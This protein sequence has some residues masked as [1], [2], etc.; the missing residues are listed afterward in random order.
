MYNTIKN[1]IGKQ[2]G[3]RAESTD[4]CGAL[5]ASKPPTSITGVENTS[6]VEMLLDYLAFTYVGLM[7]TAVQIAELINGGIDWV[8]LDRGR[9][10]Y[11]KALQCNNVTIYYDGQEDMGIHVVLTGKGMR[12]IE[13]LEDFKGWKDWI[14]D[15]KIEGVT[16]T[17]I[18]VAI[19][20]YRGKVDIDH[21]RT[22][23][24][25]MNFTTHF[26]SYKP[27]VEKRI[28]KGE[29][30]TKGECLY[31]GSRTSESYLRIYN[32]G[33]EQEVSNPWIRY[34]AEI[35]GNKAETYAMAMIIDNKPVGQLVAELMKG[36]IDF[37]ESS[38]DKNKSRR[39]SAIWW[40]ELIGIVERIKLARKPITR[41]IEEVKRWVKQQIIPTLTTITQAEESGWEWL[42]KAIDDGKTRLKGKH[43]ALIAST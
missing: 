8:V 30:R 7:M 27:Y 1:G 35:K 17:R 20:D 42:I 24:E 10:G 36:L 13:S 29:L 32:K 14:W 5:F 16:F 2:T 22:E 39:K 33:I 40:V 31:F 38:P 37:K 19:D 18:D 11:R 4:R 12:Y 26:K 28:E 21:V 25:S 3:P 43:L 41:T 23:V 34:E 15:R 9:Y 6:G